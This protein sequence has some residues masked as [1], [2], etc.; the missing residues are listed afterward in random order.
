MSEKDFEFVPTAGEDP[1]SQPPS[2]DGNFA[3]Q[4]QSF[5]ANKGMGW[6]FET[7]NNFGNEGLSLSEELDIDFGDIV[8]KIRCV[9][10][11]YN[12]DRKAVAQPDF[13]GPL[14]IVL[15]YSAIIL[16]GQ[17]EVVWWVLSVWVWGGFLIFVLA[18]SLGADVAF[19]ETIAVIGYS[20]IPLVGLAATLPIIS[21][22]SFILALLCKWI[23]TGWST[24]AAG[25]L[26]VTEDLEGKAVLLMYPIFLLFVYFMSLCD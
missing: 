14:A 23:A 3:G 9:I 18:R 10:F 16:W 6:L 8:H 13:W 12:I 26:L 17:L 7:D 19:C 2:L 4:T 15:L 11:P 22:A 21:K 5:F 20:L 1:Y 25:S 24:W